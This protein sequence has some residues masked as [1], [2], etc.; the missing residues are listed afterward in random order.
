MA[1]RYFI[2][3][4]NLPDGQIELHLAQVNTSFFEE[5]K[6]FT[7]AKSVIE[8]ITKR[9]QHLLSVQQNNAPTQTS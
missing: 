2:N 8:V 4:Q 5:Y 3:L 7:Q 6:R 9:M 1:H